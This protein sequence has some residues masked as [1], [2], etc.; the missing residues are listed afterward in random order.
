MQDKTFVIAEIGTAHGGN[1]EK[2]KIL[3]DKAFDSGADAVKFQWVYADEILHPDTGFVDLPGGKIRLYDSFKSLEVEPQF[4]ADCLCYAHSK[5]LKFVCSPFGLRSLKELLKIQPDYIK[6][7]S[8]ELNH[9]PLL[10]ELARFRREQE[11]SLKTLIPVIISSGVSKLEDIQKAIDILGTKNLT[12]LHCITFYPAPEEEYNLKLIKTLSQKFKINTGVSDHSLSPILVP[13]LAISQGA[14]MIEK[15]I[16]LSHQ[17][18]GLDDKVALVPEDFALMCHCIN[19][20]DAVMRHYGSEKGEQEIIRQLALTD[21]KEK[22]NKILGD[23]IKKLAPAEEKNYDRTNRSLH[24]VKSLTKGAK[25]KEEDIAVLR[26]EKVLTVG[27]SP[28]YYESVIGKTLKRDVK[29]GEGVL[30]TDFA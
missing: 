21:G 8:P 26:T 5:K 14:T 4:F 12:L 2:A 19:Q 13:C 11:N 18:D 1:F 20:S 30:S 17:T 23:G 27:I 24:F 7:A 3:I 9:I 6:I 29:S 22:I 15:H 16:T 10:K 25:I 28:E